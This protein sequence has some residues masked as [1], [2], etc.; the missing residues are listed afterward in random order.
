MA[1]RLGSG[2][3]QKLGYIITLGLHL[4]W[5]P[6]S[7]PVHCGVVTQRICKRP[8]NGMTYERKKGGYFNQALDHQTIGVI[9][10]FILSCFIT[11]L[12]VPFYSQ[13]IKRLYTS[14]K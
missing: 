4:E 7:N 3:T 2:T 1:K 5:F 14:L 13:A 11:C 12:N 8:E 9:F 6:E 10:E